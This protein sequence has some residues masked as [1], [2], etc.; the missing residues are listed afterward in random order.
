MERNQLI[1]KDVPKTELAGC[2]LVEEAEVLLHTYLF[3]HIFPKASVP[4]HCQR[5]ELG[6]DRYL[7]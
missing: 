5:Q 7:I 3:T 1:A 4:S 6:L 2:R